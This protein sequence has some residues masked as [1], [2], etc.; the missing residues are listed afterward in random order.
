MRAT[1]GQ[2]VVQN[3]VRIH[4]IFKTCPLISFIFRTRI[5]SPIHVITSSQIYRRTKMHT[6]AC[7]RGRATSWPTRSS[8]DQTNIPQAID[9]KMR[10]IKFFK[11]EKLPPK[12]KSVI[13]LSKSS[14]TP[15]RTRLTK[16]TAI[17]SSARRSLSRRPN[18]VK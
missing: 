6:A 4:K 10:V 1:T 12:N 9:A 11:M 5:M 13:S 2:R 7:H 15:T 3:L 18:I 14:R 8:K 16:T 17:C